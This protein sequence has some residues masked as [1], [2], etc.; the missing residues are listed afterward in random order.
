[1]KGVIAGIKR[2]EIH[3]GDGLRTTV[4][5]KGCP[6]RCMWCHNPESQNSYP[7]ILYSQDKCINCGKC[8][9]SCTHFCHIIEETHTFNRSL[10]VGCGV[11]AQNCTIG[12]LRLAGQYYTVEEVMSEVIRDRVYYEESGGGLTVSGGEPLMQIDFLECLLKTAKKEGIHTCIE[13]CGYAPKEAF[14]KIVPYTDCFLFDWK[15]SNNDKHKLF[16]GVDNCIIHKNLSYLNDI[17]AKIVLR[18]PLI[19]GYNDTEEHL[20]GTANLINQNKNITSVEIL[21][22]HP[23]G[24]SKVK[25]LDRKNNQALTV[26]PD[27]ELLDKVLSEIREKVSVPITLSV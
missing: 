13:T 27:K 17:G 4:F 23:L 9:E 6:L 7:E 26:I 11:C 16:T 14:E 12:A 19:P 18:L 24:I 5:F 20:N 25:D 22:Y 21:P 1:M 10:C 8:L 15:E 2:M 3:D